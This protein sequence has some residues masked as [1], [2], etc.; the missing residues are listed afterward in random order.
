MAMKFPDVQA[1]TL[2]SLKTF[3][4]ARAPDSQIEETEISSKGRSY[5]VLKVTSGAHHVDIYIYDDGDLGFNTEHE[6]WFPLE[7][8][9]EQDDQKRIE[10]F[11]AM[12]EKHVTI[13]RS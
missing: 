3:I 2:R 8:W 10:R 1:E 13:F 5:F 12:L 7:V 4:K 11:M 6:K 9:D